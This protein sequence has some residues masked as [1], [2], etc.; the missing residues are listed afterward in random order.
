LSADNLSIWSQIETTDPAFAKKFDRGG[1]K[2]TAINP[3]YVAR[4]LTELF[5]ACGSG[6]K[7]VVET[8]EYRDGH[9]ID[10]ETGD[11]AIIHVIRG[12]LAYIDPDTAE[13]CSTGPQYGQTTFVGSNRH[14]PFTDEEAPKKSITD[15]LGKC[16]ALLGLS[17][18]IYS[19]KWDANKY[20]NDRSASDTPSQTVKRPA[21]KVPAKAEPAPAADDAPFDTA[22]PAE[23]WSAY[24]WRDHLNQGQGAAELFN[25]FAAA[26]ATR[27][28]NAADDGWEDV[29]GVFADA[30]RESGE[31]ETTEG[32]QLVEALQA[33]RATLD[34][35]KPKPAKKKATKKKV[36]K[37]AAA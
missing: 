31:I 14:G 2:G 12:H 7:F 21:K 4:K 26:A 10:Q 32:K 11:K 35:A 19:G 17:A 34:A 8:E 33:E 1:F 36:A 23:N 3:C 13:W 28:A 27:P 24:D 9:T 5:G 15:A 30:L 25:E 6:W 37:K 16:A 29:C 18:D 20:V 22:D